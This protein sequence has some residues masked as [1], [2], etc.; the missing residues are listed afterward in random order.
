[1]SEFTVTTAGGLWI[2][3]LSAQTCVPELLIYSALMQ[4]EGD[5]YEG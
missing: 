3:E 5:N 4:K 2:I 1:M